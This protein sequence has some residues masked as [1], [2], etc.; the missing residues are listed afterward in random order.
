ML[1]FVYIFVHCCHNK[2]FLQNFV[3]ESPYSCN[4]MQSREQLKL[5]AVS[6]MAFVTALGG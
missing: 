6:Y 4:T 5:P 1:A 3:S 2:G